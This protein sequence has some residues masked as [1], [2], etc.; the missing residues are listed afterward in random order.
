MNGSLALQLSEISPVHLYW[1]DG[2]INPDGFYSLCAVAEKRN[3]PLDAFVPCWV[4][5]R[6][7]DFDLDIEYPR[8]SDYHNV[9]SKISVRNLYNL[10]TLDFSFF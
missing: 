4:R 9:P 1:P 8:E 2:S 7:P 6:K 10:S 5:L 3:L